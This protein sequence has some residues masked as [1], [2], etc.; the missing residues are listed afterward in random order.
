LQ[1][2]A[3][4]IYARG[5]PKNRRLSAKDLLLKSPYNTYAQPGLPPTPIAAVS[6]KSLLAAMA[7]AD[8]NYLYY[9]LAGKDGHHAFS[10]TAEQWQ[11][12]VEAARAQG[13]L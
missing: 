5:D 4:V 3:T 11:R 7:P 1:I 13:L 6:D 9:V 8:T 12:D 10:S 2:D